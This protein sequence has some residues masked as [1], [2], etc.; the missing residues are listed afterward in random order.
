M[1]HPCTIYAQ[2]MVHDGNY[3]CCMNTN[4][5]D[6]IKQRLKDADYEITDMARLTGIHRN[7]VKRRFDQSPPN[8]KYILE[9]EKKTG[10]DFSDLVP[11]L[12]NKRINSK[13]MVIS[14]EP[15][16][17]YDKMNIEQLKDI[18][19][20]VVG[21]KM[22]LQEKIIELQ[23]ENTELRKELAE[24]QKTKKPKIITNK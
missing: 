14:M 11:E 18:V 6:K 10:L 17:E 22:N 9:I 5:G 8:L 2:T 15:A 23:D 16:P 3:F 1:H 7:T 21:D 12:R 24:K 4:I 20:K 19:L 13:G